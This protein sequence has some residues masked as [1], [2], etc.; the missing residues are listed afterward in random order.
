MRAAF[1]LGDKQ[2]EVRTVPDPTPGPD[3]V[4]IEIKAS[5][6]CG[7]DLKFYRPPPGEMQKALGLGDKL[8]PLI[9]G[10]E[11]CGVVAEVGKNVNP[12]L[13]KVGDRVMDHH[14]CGC[15]VCGHCRLGWT[16][17][18]K[19]DMVVYG[20]TADG[21]HATYMKVPASTLV[22][23]P[24]ELSF[25]TGAAI[26]C[27]TGTAYGALRRLET[28]GR[29]TIAIFGLGPV[30]LSAVQLAKVMGAR[31][32]AIDPV[33]ERRTPAP[34]FGADVVLDP[35][36][37]D[38]SA[39]ILELTHGEGADLALDTSGVEAGRLDAV[40]CAK[41]WGKVCFVG[42]GG[43]VKLDVSAQMIRKQLTIFG[44][45]TF[46]TVIQEECARFVADKSVDV[47]KLFTDRWTLE[48]APEAYKL[49]DTQTTGKGVIEF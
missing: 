43:S 10:H 39:E 49:F 19:E 28:S 40:K 8:D 3:D 30:G 38:I 2:C 7:T 17:L 35:N 42:E 12:R 22:S 33:A 14:Y 29:D 6:M 1:F 45:W 26:S 20:A 48:Q 36:S 16:Q 44:S 24:D 41:T 11:P 37:S 34:N 47:E 5:G 25:S 15:G 31:V 18:C 32:I 13:A 23:L 4:I 27:G 9:A 46:S 21:A